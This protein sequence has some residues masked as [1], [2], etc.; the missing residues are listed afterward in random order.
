[1]GGRGKTEKTETHETEGRSCNVHV[2]VFIVMLSLLPFPDALIVKIYQGTLR[3][4]CKTSDCNIKNIAKKEGNYCINYTGAR[5]RIYYGSRS[6]HSALCLAVPRG[7][8]LLVE[9]RQADPS[10]RLAPFSRVLEAVEHPVTASQ[11]AD[12]RNGHL[13][14]KQKVRREGRVP[15]QRCADA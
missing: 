13:H 11:D 10:R 12:N 4:R 5:H 3:T 1:M 7:T 9:S 6:A 8:Y 2:H 14:N 15:Q